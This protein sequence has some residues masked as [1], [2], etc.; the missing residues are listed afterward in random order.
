[1]IDLF[2]I[3]VDQDQNKR[4]RRLF[5]EAGIIVLKS[6]FS[7]GSTAVTFVVEAEEWDPTRLL[8]HMMDSPIFIKD[9]SVHHVQRLTEEEAGDYD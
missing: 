7:H 3:T 2:F 1:M 5:A 8:D 9:G 6:A 4:A